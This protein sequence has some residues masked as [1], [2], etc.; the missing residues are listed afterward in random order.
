MD[1]DLNV[2]EAFDGLY[3]TLSGVRIDELIPA[4]ASG[5]M[6]DLREIDQVLQVIF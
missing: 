4:E 1:N 5:I 3:E 6:K 2:K